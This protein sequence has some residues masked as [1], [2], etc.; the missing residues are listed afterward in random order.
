MK[1]RTFVRI[2]LLTWVGCFSP[3]ALLAQSAAHVD[4]FYMPSL[5]RTKK[6]SVFLPSN[7]NPKLRYPILYLLHGYSGGYTDWPS[8]TKLAEYVKDIPLIVAMPDAENSWYVNS[9]TEPQDRFEDYVVKDVPQYMQRLYS[10]DTTRQAIAGL[11]MG[12]YGAMMLAFKHASQ[13]RFAG[14]L[15]GAI[16]IPRTINDTSRPAERQ[17]SPS[18]K[19]AFGERQNGFRNAHDVFFLYRQIHKDS[20]PYLYLVTGI[21]DGFR[22]FLPAHRA[23]TDLLRTYGAAYEYHE[24]PGAHN[25]QFWD[26]EIQLLIKRLREVLKF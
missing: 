18:L 5:G 10:V 22:G 26:R 13:F 19:R 9:A 15:S 4:S 7:Y 21:Q 2:C 24:T 6:V 20:L 17:L 23:F 16:T 1:K 8:K 14:S 25:W 12:G 11:S 3:Q